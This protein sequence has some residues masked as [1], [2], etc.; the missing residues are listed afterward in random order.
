VTEKERK[1]RVSS[2]PE[3][4]EQPS[5]A[6]AELFRLQAEFQSRL[7]EETLRYLRRLQGALVP[8]SPGTVVQPSDGLILRG[9][10]EPGGSVDL[11]LEVE[12]LQRVHCMLN[13]QLSPLVSDA[14]VTWFPA[15][16]TDSGSR[17]L[18][19]GTT[20]HLVI[21]VPVPAELPRGTYRG[22]LL[23]QGFRHSSV[24]VVIEAGAAP[25]KTARRARKRRKK[26]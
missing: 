19:P 23:L 13:P 16:D 6:F 3:G 14:G 24:P 15:P 10:G 26:S 2:G 11:A 18:P 8:A 25:V 5:G 4:Q 17:L 22:A 21:T 9:R 12:N 7:A 20:E 1:M